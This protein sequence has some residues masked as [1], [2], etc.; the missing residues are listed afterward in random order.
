MK[1]EG[2]YIDAGYLNDGIYCRQVLSNGEKRNVIEDNFMPE[3]FAQSHAVTEYKDMYGNYV[4]PVVFSSIKEMRNALR[5]EPDYIGMENPISQY[6][7][8]TFPQHINVNH[9]LIDKI[10]LDIETSLI[11]ETTGEKEFP[12]P[13]KA[14]HAIT[15]ITLYTAKYGWANFNTLNVSEKYCRDNFR[16]GKQ[17]IQ[18][19]TCQTEERMLREFVDYWKKIDCDVIVAWNSEEFDLPYIVN[20]IKRRLGKKF[21]DKL[22]PFGKVTSRQIPNN[23]GNVVEIINIAGMAHLDLLKLYRKFVFKKQPNYKLDNIAEFELGRKKLDYSKYKDLEDFMIADPDNYVLYNLIDVELVADLDAKIK[24]TNLAFAQTMQS[25]A[26]P[27]NVASPTNLWDNLIYNHFYYNKMVVPRKVQREITETIEGAFVKDP[28]KGKLGWGGSLDATSMYPSAIMTNNISPDTFVKYDDLP[29]ELKPYYGVKSIHKI[30]NDI[31]FVKTLVG[32]LVKYNLAY[33]PNGAFFRKDIMGFYPHIISELFDNRVR[34]KSEM[35]EWKKY[36]ETIKGK[37]NHFDGNTKVDNNTVN[38]SLTNNLAD[39][40]KLNDLDDFNLD[41]L[42]CIEDFCE[43]IIPALDTTQDSYK[44]LMNSGYGAT[45]EKRFR[46][47]DPMIG[48]AITMTGQLYIRFLESRINKWAANYLGKAD[49]DIVTRIDTDSVVSDTKIKI[50]VN[51]QYKDIEIGE[52]FDIYADVS[53]NRSNRID[54][55]VCPLKND[56]FAL[57][58]D[59]NGK[60]TVY[61]PVRYIMKHKVKKELFKIT[62]KDNEIVCT[63][64][65]SLIVL[66][67]GEVIVIKPKN[68][69]PDDKFIKLTVD[70]DVQYTSDFKIESLG[71]QE[72]WVYDIEVEKCH[73]FFGNDILLHNSVY[74]DF[75]PFVDKL[76]KGQPDND[77]EMHQFAAKL[78]KSVFVKLAEKQTDIFHTICNSYQSKMRMKHE[79]IFRSTFA[80]NKKRYAF[81]VVE[82]EDVVYAEPQI[83]ITGIE[84]VK[85]TIPKYFKAKLQEA[86]TVILRKDESDLQKFVKE[87]RD[88]FLRGDLPIEDIGFSSS[89]SGLEKYSDPKTIYSKGTPMHVRAAL[90][91]NYYANKNNILTKIRSG[92]N[93]MMVKLKLPNFTREDVIAV[94]DDSLDQMGLKDSVDLVGMWEKNFISPLKLI[95]DALGWSI[96]KQNKL[97]FS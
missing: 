31:E 67:D 17:D 91:F 54:D 12:D 92:D 11:S 27:E 80:T 8:K 6:I 18:F 50:C 60:K 81:D 63:E 75:M 88:E 53:K 86:I 32:L 84:V 1:E 52:L 51:G 79:K 78:L 43:E 28:I 61:S 65:H 4:Y 44:L 68:V 2:F 10:Y 57:G 58:F 29:D 64:D 73:N 36:D 14:D 77:G 62:V 72:E 45:L 71:E 97:F 15:S 26:L 85:S 25:H 9:N 33:C 22:S 39:L 96:K 46:Y 41:A 90:L 3:L 35:K 70:N 42:K 37:I 34:V 48:E 74:L 21:A 66:R 7:T 13:I 5:D 30:L 49:I 69:R 16:D 38:P 94:V 23:F 59:V 93:I 82:N 20:R 19:F 24:L 76:Y 87:T 47:F 55:Y 95:T 40:K 83:S 89:V 56:I